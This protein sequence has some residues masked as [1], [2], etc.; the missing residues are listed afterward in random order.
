M[1]EIKRAVL[2]FIVLS[3][4]TGVFYPMAVTVLAQIIFPKQASG[5]LIYTT[6][7]KPAG[8][9]LIGQPFSA[10]KYFWPRPSATT[11]F[12]YNALASGGS[13]LGPTNKDLISQVAERVKSFR[14]SGIRGLLPADLVT[15]SGSGL[16]PHIS[17][18]GAVLQIPRI[19]R[20]RRVSEEKIK[21]L[22]QK[23]IEGRQFGFLGAQRVN[24]LKLNLA[25]DTL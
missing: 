15:A 4:L 21:V 18:E 1:K 5:S 11:D 19:A 12:A 13:N 8:S 17:A 6:D 2:L 23:H 3:I 9:V 14:E 20:E 16:D 7:S 24:V 25:L 22:V 10:P